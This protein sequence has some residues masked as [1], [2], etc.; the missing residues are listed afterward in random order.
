MAEL[1]WQII[2]LGDSRLRRLRPQKNISRWRNRLQN[3]KWC[4]Q[5]CLK[6]QVTVEFVFDS[7]TGR[8]LHPAAI[9]E[10]GRKRE[11]LYSAA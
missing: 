4:R 6:S 5:G 8:W 9:A 1:R 11:K 10:G 3:K 2:A 7:K